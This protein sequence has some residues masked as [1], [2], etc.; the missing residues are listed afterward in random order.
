MFQFSFC[1]IASDNVDMN[2]MTYYPPKN[3]ISN[4]TSKKAE[5]VTQSQGK[6]KQCDNGTTQRTKLF[7]SCSTCRPKRVSG[8]L[9][10]S[11]CLL[12]F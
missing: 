12:F 3:G 5:K 4:R 6:G 1:F 11:M 2:S 7:E 10:S 9:V 8:Y